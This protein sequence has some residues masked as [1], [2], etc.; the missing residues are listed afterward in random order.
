MGQSSHGYRDGMINDMNDIEDDQKGNNSA[1]NGAAGEA[2]DVASDWL[3]TACM[4][5]L[6]ILAE[7]LEKGFAYAVDTTDFV[8]HTTGRGPENAPSTPL[9]PARPPPSSMFP[10]T[11]SM[12]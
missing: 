1:A 9:P 5:E 3:D 2:N 6:E 10:L 7:F 4:N 12:L 11:S 8:T